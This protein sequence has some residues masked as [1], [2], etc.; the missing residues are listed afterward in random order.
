MNKFT[1][2]AS[3]P[4]VVVVEA[5]V[6]VPV[7]VPVA[8]VVLAAIS[9]VVPTD[10]VLDIVFADVALDVVSA[11]VAVD[12]PDIVGLDVAVSAVEDPV[13]SKLMSV[14]LA[15]QQNISTL[16]CK[17]TFTSRNLLGPFE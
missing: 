16:L 2:A 8:V 12:V 4:S 15:L 11:A 9:L 7:V 3:A 6:V 10:G 17:L 1:Y 14:R 5:T 13:I